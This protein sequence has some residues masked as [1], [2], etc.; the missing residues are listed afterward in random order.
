MD[1]NSLKILSIF[2]STSLMGGI[3]L[4]LIG[5]IAG[6]LLEKNFI[7]IYILLYVINLLYSGNLTTDEDLNVIIRW[8]IKLNPSKANYEN[9]MILLYGFF[10]CPDGRPTSI[11]T[12]MGWTDDL[13]YD[14]LY[15]LIIQFVIF[16]IVGLVSIK[17]KLKYFT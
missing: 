1:Y 11:M 6:V 10:E 9:T 12:T 13:Y 15:L 5:Q 2:L 14:S 7:F 3:T 4:Q 8:L 17:I 16:F